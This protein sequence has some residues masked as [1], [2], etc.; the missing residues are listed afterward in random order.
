MVCGLYACTDNNE[1]GSTD[2]KEGTYILQKSEVVGILPNIVLKDD[3]EFT[4]TY[5]VLSS[6]IP[7]G[8]Y[9]EKDNELI[10]SED[11][12]TDKAASYVFTIDDGKLVFQQEKS[13]AL[14][15]FA[16]EEVY[17][18]AVFVYAENIAKDN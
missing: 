11:T 9:Q 1:Q 15:A 8:K 3:N 18:G 4:F 17:D 16:S 7:S 12:G 5:S 13:T 2:I 14:P 10:L 6:S